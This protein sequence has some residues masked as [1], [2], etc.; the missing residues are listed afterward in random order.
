MLFSLCTPTMN[1][2]DDLKETMP[3]RI[4]AANASPPVEIVVLD[5]NSTDDVDEYMRDLIETAELEPGNRITYRRYTGERHYWHMAHG[6]NLA[7]LSGSGEYFALLGA[8]AYPDQGYIQAVRTLIRFGAVWGHAKDL[9]GIIFCKMDEFIAAGGYDERFEFYGPE[10][11]EMD[12]RLT[13]RGAQFG[14]VPKGLMHVIE[15][16]NEKKARNYRIKANKTTMSRMMRRYFHES[17]VNQ[18]MVANP[19]GWGKW[20]P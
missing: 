5:Y 1:R 14:L 15:T 4:A 8:D 9:C 6:F 7:I 18:T 16:P 20:T 19:D 2:A 17:L 11:R 12:A 13:R 3:Y 10:D